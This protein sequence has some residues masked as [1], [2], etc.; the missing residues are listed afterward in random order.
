MAM[1]LKL[2]NLTARTLILF[3]FV[4]GFFAIII[5]TM[6]VPNALF[7]AVFPVLSTILFFMVK[8]VFD[9]Y[10]ETHR[11]NSNKAIV[12]ELQSSNTKILKQNQIPTT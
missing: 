11:N 9:N 12:N 4:V 1:N 10:N 8:S 3:V 7:D 5:I 6:L 2:S